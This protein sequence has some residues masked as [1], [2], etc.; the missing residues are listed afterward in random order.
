MA[1][2]ADS[3]YFLMQGLS[4]LGTG[5]AQAGAARAEGE[6]KARMLLLGSKFSEFQASDALR[7]G[8]LT[9]AEYDRKLAQLK[10]SQRVALAAQGVQLGEGS[11]AEIEADTAR[12]AAR[13]VVTLKSN[14]W[15]E[16]WGY[17]VQAQDQRGQAEFTRI[18][19]DFAAS[20]S[21]IGALTS[22]FSNGLMAGATFA[23]T[24]RQNDRQAGRAAAKDYFAGTPGSY[25]GRVTPPESYVTNS[26]RGPGVWGP[27]KDGSWGYGHYA[28]I[29]DE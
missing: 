23:E 7:R 20:A 15:R 28:S 1:G 17:R 13:D 25:F 27:T 16:A 22:F 29:W 6:Y 24:Q 18:A 4:G 26:G 9:V 2:Y 11:A 19:S 14:A 3:A 21:E 12:Q 8:E 10:G 5:F